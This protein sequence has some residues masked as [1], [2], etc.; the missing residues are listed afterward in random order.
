MIKKLLNMWRLNNSSNAKTQAKERLYVIGDIHGRID[1]L[2]D[3]IAL[4]EDDAKKVNQ[5]IHLIFLG[6][7][8]DRG[9]NSA[10]V[11][12]Y[13]N[14][15]IPQWAKITYLR[16]NHEQLILDVIDGTAKDAEM[17]AWLYHGGRETLASYGIGTSTVYSD[18]KDAIRA[19]LIHAMPSNHQLFLRNTHFSKIT[20]PYIFVHAGLRPGIPLD[21]QTPQDL[22]WIREPFLS[23]NGDFGAI[24]V[25]GHSIRREVDNRA[26]RIGIDTG[27]Y[28]TGR[29]TALVIEGANRR[30]L[31]TR[32]T[33]TIETP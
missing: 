14:H 22:L 23:F 29:L 27:A 30:F 18:D 25:H 10:Q 21:Q 2:M 3:M 9:P 20:G 16:G 17:E 8:I 13:L 7:Y 4:I 11:L 33:K 28:A 1:L 5:P 12:D 26:N 6:D 24:V 15:F 19:A 32:G 31:T